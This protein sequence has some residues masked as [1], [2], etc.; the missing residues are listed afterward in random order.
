MLLL[1]VP[2]SLAVAPAWAED[3]F[4]VRDEPSYAQL[5]VSYDSGPEVIYA[6]PVE[7]FYDRLS[8]YG[9]WVESRDYGLVWRPY[10]TPVDWRP[11]THGRWVLTDDGWT[12]VS[13]WEWGW[14]PFHYGR[15]LHD[16]S[17]GW[18]WVPGSEWAPAWVDWREGGGW[19]GWA[20]LPPYIGWGPRHTLSLVFVH[21]DLVV[22]ER[23]YCFVPE[24]VFLEPHIYRHF[25]HHRRHRDLIDRTHNATRYSRVNRRVVN[26]SFDHHRLEKVLKRRI[27]LH[28]IVDRREHGAFA[29]RAIRGS[30][31][32]VY[33]PR[34]RKAARVNG[35][36]LRDGEVLRER[37]GGRRAR[38][39]PLSSAHRPRG[40]E[41]IK[42]RAERHGSTFRQRPAASERRAPVIQR[43]APAARRSGSRSVQRRDSTTRLRRLRRV[44]PVVEGPRSRSSVRV[45]PRAAPA[46]RASRHELR[47]L[48]RSQSVSRRAT[49][50]VERRRTESAPVR[51][52]Q[53]QS[54][55]PRYHVHGLRSHG[56]RSLNRAPARTFG[57]APSRPAP[58]R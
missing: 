40:R 47:N 2:L 5:G 36:R 21:R 24:T 14:A 15:W 17:W 9:E 46:R 25:S 44:E 1:L 52:K 31:L 49:R 55:A 13:D 28:R 19:V 18:V 56:Q 33:R 50:R 48:S 12:W 43:H 26:G 20:P 16:P 6:D 3:N 45:A 29:G 32:E 35:R 38:V 54:A 51:S 30:R 34:L 10:R 58:R 4:Y 23:H 11:Y 42:P 53:S 39:A 22:P 57:R 8:P 7:Y 27:P 37:H 41:A